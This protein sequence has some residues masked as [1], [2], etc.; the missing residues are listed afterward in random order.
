M[1]MPMTRCKLAL[2]FAWAS[3]GVDDFNDKMSCLD[4]PKDQEP[5]SSMGCHRVGASHVR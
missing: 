3:I 1:P 4:S 5:A 2:T